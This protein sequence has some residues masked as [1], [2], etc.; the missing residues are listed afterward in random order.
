MDMPPILTGSVQNQIAQIR[1]YLVLE[2][3]KVS[4]LETELLNIKNASE[5][6]KSLT[7]ADKNELLQRIAQV[8][9]MIG[10]D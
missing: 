6:E 9:R 2:A 5:G 10:G 8:Q 7:E 1:N 3:Q 4:R